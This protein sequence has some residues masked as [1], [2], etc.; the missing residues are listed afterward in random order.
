MQTFL[1]GQHFGS[2]LSLHDINR[3]SALANAY[4]ANKQVLYVYE[5]DGSLLGRQLVTISSKGTM[6]GY[7]CY[8][9][10]SASDEKQREM[11]AAVVHT[12]CGRWA[13][14]CGVQLGDEGEPEAMAGHFWYDDGEIDWPG[15]AR[16]ALD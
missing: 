9:K 11:L 1:M 8:L 14:R 13:N 3:M 2:C 5:Q 12:F 16:T 6:L 15:S 7:H 4:D 10:V